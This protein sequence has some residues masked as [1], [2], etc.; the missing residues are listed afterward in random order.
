MVCLLGYLG[1]SIARNPFGKV[2]VLLERS[3]EYEMVVSFCAGLRIGRVKKK[4]KDDFQFQ[5]LDGIK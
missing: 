5:L 4:R 2:L 3:L 1:G